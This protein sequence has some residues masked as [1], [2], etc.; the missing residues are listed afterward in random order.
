MVAAGF[1]SR[2]STYSQITGSTNFGEWISSN[3]YDQE[4]ANHQTTLQIEMKPQISDFV[5]TQMTLYE[6]MRI[7]G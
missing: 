2:G 3:C 1:V 7:Y 5:E 4:A 6:K